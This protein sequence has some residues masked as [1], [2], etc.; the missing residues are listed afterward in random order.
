MKIED[1][2]KK[3]GE[4]LNKMEEDIVSGGRTTEEDLF[5]VTKKVDDFMDICYLVENFSDE[6]QIAK[7]MKE[8]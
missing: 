7:N 1:I 3:L 6:L 2:I 4:V 8:Y 5:I